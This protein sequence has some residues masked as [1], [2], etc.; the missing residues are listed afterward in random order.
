MTNKDS[1]ILRLKGTEATASELGVPSEVLS[2]LARAGLVRAVGIKPNA[3]GRPGRIYKLTREGST[4]A[5][6]LERAKA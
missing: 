1:A 2:R 5:R 3:K 6:K 4:L